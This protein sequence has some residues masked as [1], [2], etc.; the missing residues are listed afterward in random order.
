MTPPRPNR[1]SVLGQLALL[2]AGGAGI[3]LARERLAWPE[4]KVAFAGGAPGTGWIALP[5]TGGLIELAARIQG[6]W[7]RAVVDSGAQYS[8]IDADL[9]RRLE[10]PAATPIP[11]LAF[12]VSGQPSVTRAVTLDLDLGEAPS[13]RLR[14]L[15]AATLNLQPLSSLT[16]RPFSVL[17]GRDFLRT[18]VA[19]VDFPRRRVAFLTPQAWTPASEAF[20]A[21]V[22]SRNGALMATVQV[23]GAPAF[24]VMVDTGATGPLALSEEA[25]RAA[26]LLD[27][28][29]VRRARS[30]TLGGL[31]E[32]R[33]VR[34]KQ[35]AF[36]GHL[37][38][39]VDVQI[40]DPSLK[41]A[42][43]NGLLGLGILNRFRVGLDLSRGRMFLEGPVRPRR[44]G[45]TRRQG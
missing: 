20:A 33:S 29:A 38:P 45:R 44:R 31:G 16:S 8:A 10:L 40:Y 30:I 36:A 21:P 18:V 12:G 6:R 14:S 32:D 1:R 27:G 7:T 43:P 34:A 5:E 35:V 26:G 24:E 13:F 28:R 15:R 17:L 23:E 2:G 3:W 39:N 9:A 25:A 22:R 37:F 42:I 11:M 41:G 19:D 4:P